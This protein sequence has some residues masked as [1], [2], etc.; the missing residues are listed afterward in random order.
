[1]KKAVFLLLVGALVSFTSF[2]DEGA[3]GVLITCKIT[4][5]YLDFSKE[6][7]IDTS[8]TD[9]FSSNVKKGQR[10][11]TWSKTEC[12]DGTDL[13][14]EEASYQKLLRG[15]KKEIWGTLVHAEPEFD[16]TTSVECRLAK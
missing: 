7:K 1:M 9:Y 10:T 14:F 6:V 2:A 16:L 8:D 12:E 3:R 13:T 11:F 5:Q 15:E 4:S